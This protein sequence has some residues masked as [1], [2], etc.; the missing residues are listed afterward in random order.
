MTKL[1][2][3]FRIVGVF[4]LLIGFM[5][6]PGYFD[7]QLFASSLPYTASANVTRAFADGW[8]YAVFEVFGMGL[9]LLWASRK[10]ADN[11]SIVWLTVWLEVLHGIGYSVYLI[12]KGFDPLVTGGFVIASL[13]IIVTGVLLVRRTW[14]TSMPSAVPAKA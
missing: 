2:W 3:W 12:A 5:N 13:V 14:Q 1:K 7:N 8:G 10:P 9:F 6:L 4:Y 11:L